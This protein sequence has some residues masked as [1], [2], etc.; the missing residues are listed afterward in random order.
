MMTDLPKTDFSLGIVGAGIMGRGIAQIAA[1]A[2][3]TVIISDSRPEASNE[4]VNF[5]SSMI[6]RKAEKGKIVPEQAEAAAA[7]LSAATLDQGSA[8][9]V[10][11]K[12][13]LVIEAVAERLDVKQDVLK[14]IENAVSSE[15]IIATN[16][17]SFSVTKLAAAA[18][19]P[20]RVSGFHFF[21]PVPLMKIV[22]VIGGTFTDPAVLDRLCDIAERMGHFPVRAADSPG[23]LINHAGRAYVTEALRIVSEGICSCAEVDHIMV[24][25]AGFPMGPFELLDMTGLDVSQE[26]MESIYHQFYEEPRFRPSVIAARQKAAGLFGRKTGRGF[27]S[28]DEGKIQR[29]IKSAP[30][31]VDIAGL[32]VWISRQHSDISAPLRALLKA[33]GAHVEMGER[34]SSDTLVILTPLGDD[35]TTSALTEGVN[36]RHTVAV[37][38][39][40]GW[41]KHRTLMRTPITA[42][43]LLAQAR[44]MLAADGLPVTLIHDSPGFVAQRICAAIVNLGTDIA[45]QNIADPADIDRAVELGL[46]YPHGPLRLGDIL[47]P[48]RILAI[49]EACHNFYGDPRYRPSP[50]LKRRALLGV[51]LTTKEG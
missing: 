16:T 14:H 2:G 51:S 20:E 5:C 19:H 23:F 22:E 29:P 40:Q 18:L 38:M 50:W 10:F 17:S 24:E 37:D 46:G 4:A 47:G 44:A 26:V 25:A 41:E 13:G 1:E 45:Q 32:P 31:E 15:C 42:P 36:P 43:H 7:R 30:P 49:L 28:Y 27:Y 11:S 33:T 12:C 48:S 35:T 3:F 6:R 9:S 8:Y 34:P 21:N 39:M